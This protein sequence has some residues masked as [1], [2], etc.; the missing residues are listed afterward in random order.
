MSIP[1]LSAAETALPVSA[2]RSLRKNRNFLLVLS[3]Y[4]LSTF[5]NCFHSVAML[6]S[7]RPSPS[8]SPV[9]SSSPRCKLPLEG[10]ASAEQVSRREAC[11]VR[12]PANFSWKISH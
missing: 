4:T 2:P 12:P 8:L 5:G 3:G 1:G 9:C 10:I 6:F 7:H 11:R